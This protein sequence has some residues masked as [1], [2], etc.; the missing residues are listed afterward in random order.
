VALISLLNSEAYAR[1]RYAWPHAWATRMGWP[2]VN[3]TPAETYGDQLI[4][5]V[6]KPEARWVVVMRGIVFV[7]DVEGSEVTLAE[8]LTAPERIVG[9]YY[10]NDM[11]GDTQCGTFGQSSTG[12]YREY[13]VMNE[14]MIESW[15]LGDEQVR[16]TVRADIEKLTRF[17]D[18]IRECPIGSNVPE[19]AGRVVCGGWRGSE[20]E[21]G[22]YERVVALVN[23]H[24]LPRPAE[25]ATLVETL[26]ADLE[27][28]SI[29]VTSEA[30]D[31]EV[32][33]FDAAVPELLDGGRP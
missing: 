28:W 29:A 1:A 15:S 25:I 10:Q 6:V 7:V 12:G 30:L 21:V 8:A 26:E 9:V 4:Q 5:L 3:G 22:A 11:L 18:V 27:Q 16:D 24:Y 33:L 20:S 17:F 19:W 2:A 32:A 14:E 31:S 23:S 13:V